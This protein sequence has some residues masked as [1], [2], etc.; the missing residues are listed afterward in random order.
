MVDTL[1]FERLMFEIND[2]KGSK[3]MY[4][5][6]YNGAIENVLLLRHRMSLEQFYYI[7]IYF[8][9]MKTYFTYLIVI[10]LFLNIMY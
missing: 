4:E 1:D 9:N 6:Y 5:N 10:Y 7:S 8:L 2:N 3:H